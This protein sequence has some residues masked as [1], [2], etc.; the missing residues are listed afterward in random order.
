MLVKIVAVQARMG[1]R[2]TLEEKIHIFKQKPDFVCLPEYWLL[3]SSIPDYHRA[4]LH[5]QEWLSYLSR[6]SDELQTVLIGGTV[7]EAQGERLH[8]V[9]Y[10][11]DR[12]QIVGSY[13]KRHPVPRELERGITPGTRAEIFDCDGIRISLMI[14][15]DV[16]FPERYE[17]LGEEDVD[18]IFIPTTSAFRPNDT[19]EEKSNRDERYFVAGASS[20]GSFVVKVCGVGT[21]FGHPLQGRSLIAAP[22]GVLER[23]DIPGELHKRILTATLDIAEIRDFRVKMPPRARI[24]VG[25]ARPSTQ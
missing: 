4:A 17:E 22:W 20:S 1:E 7:V 21:I 11:L 15:G 12:G 6:L 3:D 2:L 24:A 16:F 9:S 25:Q 18:I 8:N 14:C 5:R 13:R 10:V 19:P 23:V